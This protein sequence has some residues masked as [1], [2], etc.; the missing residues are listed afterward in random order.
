VFVYCMPPLP[1][2]W[3]FFPACFIFLFIF[4]LLIRPHSSVA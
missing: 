3:F 1:L 2:T 4:G